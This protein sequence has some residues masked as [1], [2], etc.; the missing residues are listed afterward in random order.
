MGGYCTIGRD[1]KR[2]NKYN[3]PFLLDSLL[4][5]DEKIHTIKENKK[6]HKNI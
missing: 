5:L 4:G 6:K 3:K 1:I 2:M